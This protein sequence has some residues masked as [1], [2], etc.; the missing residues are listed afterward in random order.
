MRVKET[1][2]F[3]LGIS[4]S[5]NIFM[6]YT[7]LL[8]FCNSNTGSDFSVRVA[9]TCDSDTIILSY[10]GKQVI[11]VKQLGTAYYQLHMNGVATLSCS[12]NN[13]RSKLINE[14]IKIYK[15]GQNDN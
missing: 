3:K 1:V 15:E 12:V 8:D 13:G 14:I 7:E 6:L 11:S 2:E 10:K 5:C 4:P 9:Q